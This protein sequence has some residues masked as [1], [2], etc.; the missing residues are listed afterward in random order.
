MTTKE[1]LHQLIDEFSEAEA[2]AT[3]RLIDRRNADP[4]LRAIADAPEDDEPFTA[5]DETALAEVEAD[6][7]AG[8][9]AISFEEVQRKYRQP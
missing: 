9:P 6:E 7:A 4:L 2:A 5:D 8:I 3:L 1:R